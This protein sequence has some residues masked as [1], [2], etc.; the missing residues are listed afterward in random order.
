MKTLAIIA[1]WLSIPVLLTIGTVIGDPDNAFERVWP[2]W[3]GWLFGGLISAV[4]LALTDR[5]KNAP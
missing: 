5:D 1:L 4:W 2:L 3:L